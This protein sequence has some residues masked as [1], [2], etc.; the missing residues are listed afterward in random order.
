MTNHLSVSE[1]ARRIGCRPR[2]ISTLFYNRMLD[3]DETAIVGGRRMIPEQLLPRIEELLADQASSQNCN[4]K[5]RHAS[6]SLSKLQPATINDQI[7]KSVDPD[8]PEVIALGD[9]I[10]EHGLKEP[11]VITM[12]Y[13]ILSGHRRRVGCQLAYLEK[14]PV[15]FEPIYSTDP[16]FPTLLIEYNR[17]RVKSNDE[18]LREEV[19]RADPDEA[20]RTLLEHRRKT[21]R[22]KVDTL[23]IRG[24]K[25][26]CKITAAKEPFLAAIE[27]VLG[28]REDYW[29]LSDRQ[30]HYALLNNPPLIHASKADSTYRNNKKSYNALCELLTRAR[31]SGRIPFD[32]IADPTRPVTVWNVFRQPQPFMREELDNFLKG[33]YRDLMQSQPNHIEIVGEKNTVESVIKQVA[34]SY[35]IPYTIGRGYCSLPPRNDMAKRY[36]LSGKEKLI[37]LVL[38]DF[39]PEGEDIAH[40]FT[41]SMRDDFGIDRVEA[42]KVALT[43][44]QVEELHLPPQMKAKS[45]SSRRD[46]FV[47]EHGEDVWELEAIPPDGLQRMLRTT[48]D[49]IIDTNRFNEEIEADRRDA[50]FLAGVRQRAHQAVGSLVGGTSQ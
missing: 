34:E 7:Y 36:R 45:G 44:A 25:R 19:I 26:R 41:R 21:S 24:E 12:D 50:A 38:S 1:A 11:I 2:D 28:E 32:A 31:L 30:I 33:Y 8:D 20:Y 47:S 18:L 14:V 17:Q 6:V 46:R 15:R 4:G 27:T 23:E 10:A 40:S 16:T 48:I 37:L 5:L 9:S 42:I 22:I 3:D 49:S 35:C 13:V 39:D 29:P 43:A